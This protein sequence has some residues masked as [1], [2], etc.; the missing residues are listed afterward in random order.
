MSLCDISDDSLNLIIKELTIKDYIKLIRV[1]KQLNIFMLNKF[2]ELKKLDLKYKNYTE[3]GIFATIFMNNKSISE[4]I[5]PKN[6]LFPLNKFKHFLNS[7]SKELVLTDNLY[8]SS[9]SSGKLF[10]TNK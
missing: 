8:Y 4:I 1:S 10:N 7:S 9:K 3:I 5:L 6:T 2:N